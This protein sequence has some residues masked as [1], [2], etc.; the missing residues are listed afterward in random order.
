LPPNIPSN[1]Q[2]IHESDP[3]IEPEAEAPEGEAD[4]QPV[5]KKKKGPRKK[6]FPWSFNYDKLLIMAF[7]DAKE[8]KLVDPN[9]LAVDNWDLFVDQY[10][11][12]NKGL[13]HLDGKAVKARWNDKLKKRHKAWRTV[14]NWSGVGGDGVG[15]LSEQAWKEM[16]EAHPDT[17]EFQN[18]TFEYADL[19][20][21]ALTK[22]VACFE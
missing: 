2:I 4:E 3:D 16:I 15:A 17:E 22:N 9:S 21:Q 13:P 1:K 12:K 20:E 10:W 6:A 14:C 8:Q 5:Q 19:M 7:I 18:F 11:N